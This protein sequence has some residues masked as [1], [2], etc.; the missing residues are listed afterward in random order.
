MIR[1]LLAWPVVVLIST[2][3]VQSLRAA[4]C[5][6]CS[7]PASTVSADQ[8]AMP[9]VYNRITYKPVYET[10]SQICYRPVY[11]TI[12]EQERYTVSR[13]VYEQHVQ[14]ERYTVCR[15]VTECYDVQQN[16]T[17]YKPVYEQHVRESLRCS[18][19]AGSGIPGCHTLYD[20]QN[21][22]SKP[23]PRSAADVLSLRRGKLPGRN[24]VL[25][26][27]TS[28][29]TARSPSDLHGAPSDRQRISSAG[30]LYD[31][32]P[33]IRT[34]RVPAAV[35]CLPSKGGKLSSCDSLLHLSACLRTARLPGARGVL[36]ARDRMPDG[37]A[38][39]HVEPTGL[40]ER[41]EKMCTGSWA[42]GAILSWAG[43][44]QMLQYQE[45]GTSTHV[46]V[47]VTT[48]QVKR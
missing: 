35:L 2:T 21:G 24:S 12:M 43:R 44:D 33:R 5:G 30:L 27:S 45:P 28:L 17:I 3:I 31:L 4:H 13:P 26:L 7:Y 6:A 25:H 16:Y 9:V 37:N 48:A 10:H 15:P 34:A 42:G 32:P 8:C 20:L 22:L 40:S 29:R 14:E 46:L 19:S 1:T 11:Q 38:H 41:V 18:A 39:V 47:A 36:S 23:C